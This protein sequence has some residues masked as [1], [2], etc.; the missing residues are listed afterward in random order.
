[1]IERVIPLVLVGAGILVLAGG[2]IVVRRLG[3]RARVGRILASTSVVDLAVARSLATSGR[4]RY[5]AVTGRVDA[6]E[7]FEDEHHR[8]LVYRRTRLETLGRTGWTAIE[9]QLETVPFGLSEGPETIGLDGHDLDAGLVVVVREAE[10]T[11]GEIPDRIPAGTPPDARVRL[12]IEHLSSVDH[13]LALGVPV[14]DPERGPMLR[15]GLGRPLVLTNLE[16]D[17]AL[18]LLASGRRRT[19][20]AA[21]ALLVSGV[22]LAGLGMAW[23]VVDAIA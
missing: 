20:I 1:M 6:S 21:S 19:A 18:R 13:A 8:P 22:V 2:W 3:P 16:R 17:E 14:V 15:P 10:G 12:R 11:A 5:V 9:D 4:T 7:E 23:L